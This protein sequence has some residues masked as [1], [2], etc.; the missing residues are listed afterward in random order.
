MMHALLGSQLN[1]F[2]IQ[3]TSPEI[4]IAMAITVNT[5]CQLM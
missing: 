5:I 2:A 1:S 4:L 3:T